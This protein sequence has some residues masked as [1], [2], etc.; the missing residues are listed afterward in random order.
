[1]ASKLTIT[2]P[3]LLPSHQTQQHNSSQTHLN[4]TILSTFQSI[5]NKTVLLY[6]QLMY[7]IVN[8]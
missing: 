3:S 8:K 2:T 1:M 5:Y 4:Q 7:L 6:S